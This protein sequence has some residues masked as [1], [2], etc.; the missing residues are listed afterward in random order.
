MSEQ[1]YVITLDTPLGIRK[2]TLELEILETK[3]DGYLSIFGNRESVAGE[4]TDDGA[5]R[6]NGKFVTLMREFF[7]EATG[8]ITCDNIAL[9]LRS[10]QS[11]FPLN[12]V[13]ITQT[14][15]IQGGEL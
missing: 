14:E 8:Y 15:Q 7:Y 12:G 11:V 10:G 6:L 13:A 5:C 3:I 2:G 4:L 1:N 9:T